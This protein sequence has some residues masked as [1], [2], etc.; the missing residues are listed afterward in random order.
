MRAKR[1]EALR[2]KFSRGPYRRLAL[3]PLVAGVKRCPRRFALA[4][5]LDSAPAGGWWGYGIWR[6]QTRFSNESGLK[7]GPLQNQP[8]RDRREFE[9]KNA[10]KPLAIRAE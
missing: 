7:Y 3:P 9:M 4:G 8:L 6:S 10:S 5:S 2:G 1:N